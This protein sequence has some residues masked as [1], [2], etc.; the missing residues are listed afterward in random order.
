MKNTPKALLKVLKK[1]TDLNGKAKTAV[2]LG[3]TETNAITNWLSR[4]EVPENQREKVKNLKHLIDV[5]PHYF[6]AGK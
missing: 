1:C 3:M 4:E 2:A 6:M 5:T